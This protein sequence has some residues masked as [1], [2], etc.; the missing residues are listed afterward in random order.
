MEQVSRIFVIFF[1]NVCYQWKYKKKKKK[2]NLHKVYKCRGHL[3]QYKSAWCSCPHT[4]SL[5]NNCTQPWLGFPQSI[6]SILYFLCVEVSD[7]S[8]TLQQ[9]L[10]QGSSIILAHVPQDICRWGPKCHKV[11]QRY[12]FLIIF[13]VSEH[14]SS[15]TKNDVPLFEEAWTLVSSVA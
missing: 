6:C 8:A 2:K 3:D 7:Q 10:V 11:P 15:A 14:L 1:R 12:I 5:Q 4:L 9:G 13:F